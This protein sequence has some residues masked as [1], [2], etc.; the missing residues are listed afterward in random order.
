M[1][2][3]LTLILGFNFMKKRSTTR[4]KINAMKVLSV[5]TCASFLTIAIIN[6][7]E[8]TKVVL[9]DESCASSKQRCSESSSLSCDGL[10]NGGCLL[11][12]D[13]NECFE[14][15]ASDRESVETKNIVGISSGFLGLFFTFI[16]TFMIF[17]SSRK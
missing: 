17:Y 3:V 11:Q 16:T 1:G 12:R 2:P 15:C 7:F 4:T 6:V 8:L 10:I 13:C 14:R 9:P 5:L